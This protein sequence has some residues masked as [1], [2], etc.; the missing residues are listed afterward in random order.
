[1]RKADNLPRYCAV[2]K[3]SRNLNFLDP[4]GPAWPV[5]SVLYLLPVGIG[6]YRKGNNKFRLRTNVFACKNGSFIFFNIHVDLL[7]LLERRM[8]EMYRTESGKKC[9]SNFVGKVPGNTF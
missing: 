8:R 3:N 2:V 6:N 4:S 7:S 9:L 5:T 1:M